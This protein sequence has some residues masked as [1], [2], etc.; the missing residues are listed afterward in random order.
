MIEK[1]T[2]MFMHYIQIIIFVLIVASLQ[3]CHGF[4][5]NIK[6][7]ISS[8]TLYGVSNDPY[9][10]ADRAS[11]SSQAGDRMVELFQPLGIE[12]DQD[13][14]GNVFV[15]SIEKNSR[16]EKTNMIFVGDYITKASATFGNDMWSTRRVGLSRVL[17]TIRMR[18]TSPVRLVLE[19][20][21]QMEEQRLRAI[22]FA[23]K[24]DEE[25]KIQKIKDDE[26]LA[27]MLEEDKKLLNKRKGFLGLW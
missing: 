13:S 1:K 5:P 26:L 22:A 18:N 16:A 21:D 15:K 12:L 10:R 3:D 4:R 27:S 20:P 8:L 7:S 11:R 14:E 17:T 24:S 25:K 6:N 19:N 9:S 23:E 2:D